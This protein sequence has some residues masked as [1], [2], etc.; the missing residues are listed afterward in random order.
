M[1]G[2]WRKSCYAAAMVV[3]RNMLTGL[4]ALALALGTG[5]GSCVT[6]EQRLQETFAPTTDHMT[7][8]QGH[9][10]SIADI[11]VSDGKAHAVSTE[12]MGEPESTHDGCLKCCGICVL[13]SVLPRDPL[14]I[15]A[16]AVSRFSF[17]LIDD[18][19][20]G[21]IVLVDPDIPKQSA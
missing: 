14:W 15:V 3:V 2:R 20:R 4:L 21:R 11:R 16:P 8:H 10:H 13:T 12:G 18:Q 5:W 7:S 9:K 17:A 6:L 1:I 19:L